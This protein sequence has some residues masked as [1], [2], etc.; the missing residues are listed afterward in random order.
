MART[1]TKRQNKWPATRKTYIPEEIHQKLC[2]KCTLEDVTTQE[3]VE[4]IP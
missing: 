4:R 1:M 2:V 3:F